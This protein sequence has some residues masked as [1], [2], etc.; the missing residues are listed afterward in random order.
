[1]QQSSPATNFISLDLFSH[2]ESAWEFFHIRTTTNPR[3]SKRNREAF[4]GD[5]VL[6]NC[7][8]RAGRGGAGCR[9][10]SDDNPRF[11][12]LQT[13]DKRTPGSIYFRHMIKGPPV[14][15]I[16]KPLNIIRTARSGYFKT[17]QRSVER[18]TKE[19]PKNWRVS[20]WSPMWLF[21]Q[22]RTAVPYDTRVVFIH[23]HRGYQL[24]Y[25]EL[26]PLG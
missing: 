4:S 17:S 23:V 25:P 26:Y 1:V 20:T 24:C 14:P 9:F 18:F 12:L 7:L 6:F 21:Q 15:V 8:C 16:W 2:E 19:P 3:K 13:Y 5:R 22:T 10:H 11:H